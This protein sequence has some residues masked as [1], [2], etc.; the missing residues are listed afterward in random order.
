MNGFQMMAETARKSGQERKAELYAFLGGCSENDM[1]ELF[2]SSAFN[3]ICKA[4]LRRACLEQ[5][6]A[7]ELTEEDGKKLRERFAG[8]FDELSA[9]QAIESGSFFMM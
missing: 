3:E 2:N 5:V 7:G 9:Q 6:E 8:L 4:Y 1:C